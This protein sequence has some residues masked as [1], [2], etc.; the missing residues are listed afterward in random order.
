MTDPVRTSAPSSSARARRPG[1][2]DVARLA[3]VSQ[4]TVS[5]VMNDEPHVREDVRVRV[6]QAA[7]ELGYRRN[8]VARALN[9]GRTHRI[10]VVSLGTALWGPATLLMAAERAAR[11]TGYAVSLVNTFE[12]DP[13]GVVGAIDALL[14]QGV[15]GIVLSEPIDGGA[16]EVRVDVPV[17]TLGHFPALSAPR[18]LT[19]YGAADVAAE[20]ATQHLLSLGHVTVRHVAGPQRWWSARERTQGWRRAL[21]A[22]GAEERPVLFGD[23]SPASGH[24]AGRRLLAE[25]PHLT[26]VF[27][28]NDDMAIGMMRALADG[29]RRVPDD[30]SVVGFDD[31][32]SAAYLSPPLTT[33][34]QD[35][36][37][38]AADGL[39]LLLRAIESPGEPAPPLPSPSLPL[40]VRG[41]TARPGGYSARGRSAS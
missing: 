8:N 9:S 32:P 30:V 18:V 40:V 22:A 20:V 4:K 29:G 41:S 12:D 6:L 3:G 11:S 37:V 16:V 5:R 39:R 33:V 17:L 31:I 21:Q 14:E 13:E 24:A 35:F 28:A 19:V 1:S 34:G 23:W 26:A 27:V 38:V 10:G 7:R 36:D 15:D 25:D 2:T